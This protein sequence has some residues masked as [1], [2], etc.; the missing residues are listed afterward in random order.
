MIGKLTSNQD[1]F[2]AAMHLRR[3]I[4]L[5]AIAA[6][7]SLAA[8]CGSASSPTSPSVN[9]PFTH[10]DLRAGSGA[11]AATGKRLSVNYTGWLY[12]AT[13]P[14]HK[15]LQF[16]SGA[17]AFTLGAGQVIKGWDQGFA[18][19]KVGGQRRL[20][21]PPSLAYGASGNGPIPG[22]ATLV[23]DVELLDV[24]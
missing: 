22:N 8:A 6:L 12:D 10:T 17:Y 20:V 3:Y 1:M 16:D 18:G 19:M 9:V 14:D 7:A 4:R 24:Q 5:S 11:D 23:F 21:I 13:K 2:T 15:G